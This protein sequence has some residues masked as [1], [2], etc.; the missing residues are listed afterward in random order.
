METFRLL[1]DYPTLFNIPGCTLIL[2]RGEGGE[3]KEDEPRLKPSP[4]TTFPVL[5]RWKFREAKSRWI[6]SIL[7]PPLPPATEISRGGW[8]SARPCRAVMRSTDVFRPYLWSCS[9]YDYANAYLSSR[10]SWSTGGRMCICI[11][12]YINE[13]ISRYLKI[14]ERMLLFRFLWRR[15]KEDARQTCPL[16]D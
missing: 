6:T 14:T 3:A 5:P 7:P 15:N 11:Y 4:P 8:I 9:R 13:R 10:V 2:K 16:T 12:V 1:A